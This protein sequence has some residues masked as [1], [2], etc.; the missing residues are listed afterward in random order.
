VVA[1]TVFFSVVLLGL[2][3]I[4]VVVVWIARPTAGPEMTASE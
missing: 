4:S 3:F 1:T 2:Y